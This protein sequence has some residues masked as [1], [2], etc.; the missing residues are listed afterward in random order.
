MS[1]ITGCPACG[2]LFKV[3][4]DQLRISE[5]WVR[6]GHCG[7]VFDASL[8]LQPDAPAEP[9]AAVPAPAPQPQP[10]AARAEADLATPAVSRSAVPPAAD[11]AAAEAPQSRLA[12]PSRPTGPGGAA[13]AP[14]RPLT[15]PEQT[16]GKPPAATEPPAP[17]AD[18]A[19]AREPVP[20]VL[21]PIRPAPAAG[22]R[23]AP[24]PPDSVY[25]PIELVRA[26][27]EARVSR[28]LVDEDHDDEEDDDDEDARDPSLAQVSFVRQARRKAFWRRTSVRLALL[29]VALLL[30]ASLA[31]QWALH[32]RDRLAASH[33]QWRPWL[34]Q[35]CRPLDCR[36]GPPRRIDAILIDSSGFTRLRQDAYRLGF[37]L[38]NQAPHPVA[39][40]A[41]ELTLT[42]TQDQPL[43]RRVLL[44]KELHAPGDT[45]AAA[46][47]WSGSVAIAVE[48]DPAAARVA[49]Y[50]LLAFYP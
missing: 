19:P 27:V 4:P 2:T 10:R 45:L 34:E 37:T 30:S 6:C 32:D 46:S 18:A 35:L 23:P 22:A 48:A 41:L 47:D 16:P 40:P 31:A 7:D 8:H 13:A 21:V 42:D 39:V 12:R 3:V 17:A 33:P 28:Y 20:A 36:I 15:G 29:G 1:M 38:K 50:R 24:P 14:A 9:P 49:G 43:L 11:A 44:P 26:E 5:G 25:P